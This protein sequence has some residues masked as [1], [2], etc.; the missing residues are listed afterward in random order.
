MT[1]NNTPL[2]TQGP[3][4]R[5]DRARDSVNVAAAAAWHTAQV[6]ENLKLR[7]IM[8][9][10]AYDDGPWKRVAS[11][12]WHGGTP[13][14]LI[15][16]IAHR[17]LEAGIRD[18]MPDAVVTSEEAEGA[19]DDRPGADLYLTDPEDGTDNGRAVGFGDAT[20]VLVFTIGSHGERI[21]CGAVIA[22][23]TY[24]LKYVVYSQTLVEAQ[25]SAPP[26]GVRGVEQPTSDISLMTSFEEIV[27]G[28]P[29]LIAV[30]GAR[31]T[32]RG[33]AAI[34]KLM[35][36]E[37]PAWVVG[38]AGTPMAV[39]L[40]RGALGAVVSA[41]E[42]K[43]RDVAHLPLV[44]GLRGGIVTDL[45]GE[46]LPVLESFEEGVAVPPSIAASSPEALEVVLRALGSLGAEAGEPPRSGVEGLEVPASAG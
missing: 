2:R 10:E 14:R 19:W 9:G 26:R 17:T 39:Q 37:N 30:L 42:Q 38:M 8:S 18:Y 4:S 21:F 31:S 34:R 43:L 23:A 44:A 41:S 33:K 5:L 32:H 25:V 1:T 6:V 15:D 12:P 7:A 29:E 46:V 27:P 28:D 13:S 22:T 35:A 16:L 36:P 3:L 11:P 24:L 45:V 40:V 20:V